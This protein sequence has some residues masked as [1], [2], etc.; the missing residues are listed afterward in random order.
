MKITKASAKAVKFACMNFHYAKRLPVNYVAYSVFE[1]GIWC[2]CVIFGAGIMGIEKPYALPKNS[3]WEL[4]RVALNGKQSST[5]KAVSI[6]VRLFSKSAPAV[7]MLVS[8]ADSDQGHTGTIYQAM[9]WAFTGSNNTADAYIDP[10]TGNTVH[11]RSHSPTGYS[12]R[13]NGLK[14]KVLNT[15][16]L[17]RVKT[18]VKHKYIY[19]LHKSVVPLCKSLAKPYPKKALEVHA[20]EHLAPSQ[21][22]GGSSPTPALQ[23]REKT[24]D[25]A[26]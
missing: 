13:F 3:V 11:S 19:P 21:E 17:I 10:S 22:V 4:V 9:N 7:K 18:G 8:Y 15:R 24:E 1:N 5:S 6:C 16:N 2:G 20:V 12:V 26:E 14:K 25:H 23:N